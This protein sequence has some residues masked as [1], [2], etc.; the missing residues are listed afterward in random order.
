MRIMKKPS[1]GIAG[2]MYN[3]AHALAPRHAFPGSGNDVMGSGLFGHLCLIWRL[4]ARNGAFGGVFT[5][6]SL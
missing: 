5:F 6:A 3:I 1:T 2:T 4:F